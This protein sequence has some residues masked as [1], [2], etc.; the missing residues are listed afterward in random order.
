MSTLRT[1][2][3]NVVLG[4][5]RLLATASMRTI[6]SN[7]GLI[8][9]CPVL[10][11]VMRHFGRDILTNRHERRA[12]V[13]CSVSRCSRHLLH[14]LTL[15]CAG[16]VVA[17][18]GKVPFKIGSVRGERG[19]L[20][21]HLFHPRRQAKIGTY[22]LMAHTFRLHVLSV[23]GLRPSRRWRPFLSS[24]VNVLST[25]NKD[26][27]PLINEGRLQLK[28]HTRLSRHKKTSLNA[29][30]C[31]QRLSLYTSTNRSTSPFSK[32]KIIRP[33][34]F[35]KDLPPFTKRERPPITR[36]TPYT[37]SSNHF[38]QDVYPTSYFPN[39]K[40]ISANRR[41]CEQFIQFSSFKEGLIYSDFQSNTNQANL[42]VYCKFLPRQP[43]C[44]P[45]RIIIFYLFYSKVYCLV[46]Y[47]SIFYHTKL[48]QANHVYQRFQSITLLSLRVLLPTN[49]WH[50]RG[51]VVFTQGGCLPCVGASVGGDV[52]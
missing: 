43:K 31:K 51:V 42:Q 47:Y 7:G 34:P 6:V 39:L 33:F 35:S 45:Q 17:K 1:K 27:F 37:K 36:K 50:A 18:L 28:E 25:C 40:T 3:S 5:K 12:V 44:H 38:T 26:Y 2:T 8:F 24:N 32:A 29:S 23:S 4:A 10:R 13:G 9:G 11:G 20:I 15:K 19:S 30:L 48:C 21:D 49:I 52:L 14:R 16:R 46:L 22:Q 41:R